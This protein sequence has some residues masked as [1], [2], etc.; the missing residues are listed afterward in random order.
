MYI[1]NRKVKHGKYTDR[2][3]KL[4]FGLESFKRG[5]KPYDDAQMLTA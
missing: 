5:Y 2:S 1:E 4:N 3:I